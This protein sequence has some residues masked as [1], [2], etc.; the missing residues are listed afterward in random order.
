MVRWRLGASMT[1]TTGSRLA[2]AVAL[3][4]SMVAATVPA[5]L[6]RLGG[7]LLVVEVFAPT[8]SDWS[9]STAGSSSCPEYL[10]E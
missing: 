3:G 7:R 9:S 1:E 10:P 4:R 5:H 8:S 6:G 2:S